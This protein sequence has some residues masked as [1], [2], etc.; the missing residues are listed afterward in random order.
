[1]HLGVYL[2]QACQVHNPYSCLRTP[3]A[4]QTLHFQ[5]LRIRQHTE[6]LAP[7]DVVR[8]SDLH[9]INARIELLF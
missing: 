6:C 1:M 9:K 8:L 3:S 4:L 7:Y 2:S 5:H